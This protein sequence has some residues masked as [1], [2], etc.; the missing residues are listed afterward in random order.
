M[1]DSQRQAT[2]SVR[3]PEPEEIRESDETKPFLLACSSRGAPGAERNRAGDVA[4]DGSTPV[5]VVFLPTLAL[6][7]VGA[8]ARLKRSLGTTTN[9]WLTPRFVATNQGFDDDGSSKVSSK[10]RFTGTGRVTWSC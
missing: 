6:I 3:A 4:I 2:G 10:P 7:F 9:N 8:I 5:R 1:H